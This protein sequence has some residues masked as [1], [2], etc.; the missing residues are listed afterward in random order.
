MN[1]NV[2]AEHRS[3]TRVFVLL[4]ISPCQTRDL[5]KQTWCVR[6]VLRNYLYRWH[7]RFIVKY[8]FQ[9]EMKKVE[10]L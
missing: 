9:N 3:F 4:G 8:F 1:F 2:K 10:W 7:K 6:T 5:L